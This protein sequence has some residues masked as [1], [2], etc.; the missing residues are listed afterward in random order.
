VASSGALAELPD[1][2]WEVPFVGS[3]IP[4]ATDLADLRKGGNCQLW[5]YG[6]LGWFGIDLPAWRSDELWADTSMTR[7]VDDPE[8]LDLVLY[9]ATDEPFG[10]HVGVWTGSAVAHLCR[11]VGRPVVW[12]ETEL[13][14]RPRYACRVGVK[15]AL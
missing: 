12:S 3:R 8:P 4:G 5:A 1:W 15:R 10:A 7:R 14:S 11:E 2:Y 13:M 9:N 6:V